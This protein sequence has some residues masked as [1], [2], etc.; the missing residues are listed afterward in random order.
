MKLPVPPEQLKFMTSLKEPAPTPEIVSEVAVAAENCPLLVSRVIVNSKAF[1]LRVV[2]PI[3][4]EGCPRGQKRGL[5]RMQFLPPVDSTRERRPRRR[6][7]G[8]SIES[9]KTGDLLWNC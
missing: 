4:P 5:R 1:P 2:L 6:Y 9:S 3:V 7:D 8:F